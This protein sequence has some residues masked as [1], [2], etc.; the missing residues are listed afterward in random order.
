MGTRATRTLWL[1]ALFLT[2]FPFAIDAWAQARLPA[3]MYYTELSSPAARSVDIGRLNVVPA[4]TLLQDQELNQLA[5]WLNSDSRAI[6]RA[7]V[8]TEELRRRGALRAGE[9]IVGLSGGQALKIQAGEVAA[10]RAVTGVEIVA[11]E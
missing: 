2:Q 9:Q 4:S 7:A 6:A 5:I 3:Q 8:L 10:L 11:G 1:T